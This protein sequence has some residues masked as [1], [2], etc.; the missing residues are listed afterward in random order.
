M[1]IILLLY[2]L[3]LA[4]GYYSCDQDSVGTDCETGCCD[5]LYGFRYC[6]PNVSC[7]VGTL[8][9]V[10][11]VLIVVGSVLGVVILVV[12]ICCIWRHYR[13]RKEE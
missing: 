3:V 9:T 7:A 1:K 10:A 2:C 4:Q 13:K 5:N 11:I 12:A 6:A 8:S